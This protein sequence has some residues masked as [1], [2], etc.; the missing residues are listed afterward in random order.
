MTEESEESLKLF[1]T[2]VYRVVPYRSAKSTEDQDFN[3]ALILGRLILLHFHL[4]V[5]HMI[6]ILAVLRI[7]LI[8]LDHCRMKAS[9]VA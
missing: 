8:S 7:F 9:N 1:P 2:D 3:K 6:G 4:Q 5:E